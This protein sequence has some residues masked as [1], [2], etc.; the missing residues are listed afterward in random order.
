MPRSDARQR[1]GVKHR[2][3]AERFLNSTKLARRLTEYPRGAVIFSQGD[4]ATSVLYVQQGRVKLSVVSTT[5]KEAVVGVVSTGDFFGEGALAGQ[6]V[7]MNTATAMIASRILAIDRT[8]MQRLLRRQ[9]SLA[10]RFISYL[11]ARNTQI[12]EDLVDRLFN[13]VEK[14]FARTLILMARYGRAEADAWILPKVSQETLAEMVG[15]TRPR[16]NFFMNKF[17]GLGFID[18]NGELVIRT[19]LLSVILHE[20]QKSGS[21]EETGRLGR[22]GRRFR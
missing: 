1:R 8:R 6:T 11:L 20:G 15:T 13:S 21:E 9:P 18:Y 12:E 14:R 19:S 2:F 7:R 16:I 3:D 22:S 4:A 5:G 17:R 10:Q